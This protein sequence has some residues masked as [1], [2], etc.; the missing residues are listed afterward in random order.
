MSTI[1]KAS[2]KVTSVVCQA[3]VLLKRLLSASDLHTLSFRQR[4]EA[5]LLNYAGVSGG[6]SIKVSLQVTL[7]T[8]PGLSFPL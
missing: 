7:P 5:S 6:K 1:D 4:G 3:K 2:Q 8:C